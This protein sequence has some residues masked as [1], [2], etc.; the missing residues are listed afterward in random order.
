MNKKILLSSLLVVASQIYGFDGEVSTGGKLNVNFTPRESN[1]EKNITGSHFRLEDISYNIKLLDLNVN[2]KEQGLSLYTTIKSS[3]KDARINDWDKNLI[4]SN[5]RVKNHDLMTKLSLN[6]KSPK[7][8]GLQS[9]TNLTY[10]VDDITSYRKYDEVNDSVIDLTRLSEYIEENGE[11]ESLGNIK[12]DTYL[13]GKINDN[14]NLD[15]SAKYK[16]NQLFRFDRDKS[17]FKFNAKADGSVN[18]FI[19]LSGEYNLD[20][21]LNEGSKPYNPFRENLGSFADFLSG[22]YVNILKQ[23]FKFKTNFEK[24]VHNIDLDSNVNLET[25]FVG[26]ENYTNPVNT[27]YH[28]IKPNLDLKYS[29]NITDFKVYGG[30]K[31]EFDI[32][33]TQYLPQGESSVKQSETL[34]A[35]TPE[36]YTGFEYSKVFTE[37]RKVSNNFRVAYAPK[38]TISPYIT[39][40]ENLSHNFKVENE[41]SFEYELNEKT[42]FK[43]KLNTELKI[44]VIH[45]EN[46]NIEGKLDVDF[47]VKHKINEKLM[48]EGEIKNIFSSKSDKKVLNPES[49]KEDFKLKGTLTYSILDN[50]KLTTILENKNS[51]SS[52]YY[53]ATEKKKYDGSSENESLDKKSIYNGK[54]VPILLNNSLKLENN[55]EYTK[56]LSSKLDLVSKLNTLFKLDYIALKPEKISTYN[57]TASYI[58]EDKMLP[59]ASSDRKIEYNVGGSIEFKPNIEFKYIPLDKLEVNTNVGV[60]LIFGRE[61]VN[62]INDSKRPDDNTYGAIDKKFKFKKLSPNMSLNIKYSW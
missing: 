24:D 31:N 29:R 52:N 50:L 36:A 46:N 2:F 42:N 3:R 15:I 58:G 1:E 38:M 57:N 39:L 60:D 45:K 23:D 44:P 13:K 17:Y 7:F 49:A 4:E 5:E 43:G 22:N 11:K 34:A 35:Y 12:I 9:E 37:K 55:L 54:L 26:G 47:N 25:Y 32:V 53:Y 41:T 61:V 51:V 20:I 8:Y 59:I 10:Y 16:A 28:N 56:K 48:F 14:V 40:E 18:K 30:Y 27:I 21:D 6:Y 62:L 19:K 33:H